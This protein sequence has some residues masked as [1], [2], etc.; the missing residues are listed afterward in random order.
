M[1]IM[2]IR[3]ISPSGGGDWLPATSNKNSGRSIRLSSMG[4][5][6]SPHWGHPTPVPRQAAPLPAILSWKSCHS[7]LVSLKPDGRTLPASPPSTAP[8][9]FL[10]L[11]RSQTQK[12]T[13]QQLPALL[14]CTEGKQRLKELSLMAASSS[15]TRRAAGEGYVPAGTAWGPCAPSPSVCHKLCHC[16]GQPNG[17]TGSRKKLNNPQIKSL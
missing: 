8:R 17:F 12:H 11:S 1:L 6:P 13:G 2:L 4:P 7:R 10:Y 3:K 16:H 5:D 15:A 9:Y 14:S